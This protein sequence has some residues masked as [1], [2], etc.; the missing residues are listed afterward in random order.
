MSQ[1]VMEWD[2]ELKTK[3]RRVKERRRGRKE[4]VTS[5][6]MMWLITKATASVVFM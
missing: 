1:K 2:A 3:D 5:P 6:V 4:I